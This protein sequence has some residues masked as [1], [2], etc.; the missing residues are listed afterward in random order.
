MDEYKSN[1]CCPFDNPEAAGYVLASSL[2]VGVVVMGNV[3]F[4][5]AFLELAERD[6]GCGYLYADDVDD[7]PPECKEKYRGI[8]PANIYILVTS[9]A[10]V[11]VAILVPLVGAVVDN[12][13]FRKSV[14]AGSKAILAAIS[15]VQTSL[16]RDNWFIM[17][18]LQVPA[19]AMYMTHILASSAYLPETSDEQ[20]Q[21]NH[22]GSY[23]T[24]YLF[25]E[26]PTY[27]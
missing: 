7:D 4:S 10:A 11:V 2:P 20:A 23:S 1:A 9:A 6:V 27:L 19:I 12:T 15:L 17:T 18:V 22:A 24:M 14:A 21:L 16:N 26:F 25:G 5:V 3:F 8:R 13:R